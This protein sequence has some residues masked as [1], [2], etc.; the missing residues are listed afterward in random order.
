M[1]RATILGKVADIV[2]ETL[3]TD[4]SD[5]KE[6]TTFDELNADS[7]DRLELVTAFED[8]FGLTIPDDD[9]AKIATVKDAVDAIENAS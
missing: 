2:A 3:G 5:I 4:V 9:L 7:L 6:N 8:E 1:D